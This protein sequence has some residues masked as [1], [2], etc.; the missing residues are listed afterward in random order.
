MGSR[1]RGT[2]EENNSE[3][4]VNVLSSGRGGGDTV[5]KFIEALH[6]KPEGC[7]FDSRTGHWAFSFT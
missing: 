7:G 4:S 2:R 5:A 3:W 1:K 6:Y